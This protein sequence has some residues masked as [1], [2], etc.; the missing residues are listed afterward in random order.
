MQSFLL[1]AVVVCCV[2]ALFWLI[3]KYV[4]DLKSASPGY[5]QFGLAWLATMILVVVLPLHFTVFLLSGVAALIGVTVAVDWWSA[6][7]ASVAQ[8]ARDDMAKAAIMKW[9]LAAMRAAASAPAPGAKP[10]DT[11]P[12]TCGQFVFFVVNVY[13]AVDVVV[14]VDVQCFWWWW[15]GLVTVVFIF[16]RAVHA[17]GRALPC[18]AVPCH[19]IPCRDCVTE[20]EIF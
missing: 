9:F 2:W 19:A 16:C 20:T 7:R 6:W 10:Q 12:P 3:Q 18:R 17:V 15:L 5:Y 4:F 11:A 8:Q 13:N 1:V 14:N